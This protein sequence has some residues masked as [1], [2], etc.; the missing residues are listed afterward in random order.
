MR[1]RSASL[2]RFKP[3]AARRL[4][5]RDRTPSA[6]AGPVRWSVLYNC[7]VTVALEAGT[8]LDR[9][10]IRLLDSAENVVLR[11][12]AIAL[13][14][15]YGELDLVF[16]KLPDSF[17]GGTRAV[18]IEVKG[19]GH[20]HRSNLFDIGLDSYIGVIDAIE[21]YE[22][23]GWISPLFN[24]DAFAVELF[25]DGE[26][27]LTGKP[28]RFRTDMMFLSAHGG[29]NGFALP[30][31]SRALDGADH[32]IA[33]RAGRTM[34]RSPTWRSQPE[35]RVDILEQDR[36][37][38]WY[39][40]RGLADRPLSLRL[41]QGEEELASVQSFPRPDVYAHLGRAVAGFSFQNVRIRSGQSIVAGSVD[42]P[43]VVATIHAHPAY[44]RVNALRDVARSLLL[45]RADSTATWVSRHSLQRSTISAARIGATTE[46]E[47][48]FSPV[49]KGPA[50]MEAQA[51]GQ[52][53]EP[54]VGK[55][56]RRHR[57][58]QPGRSTRPAEAQA[59]PA[60]AGG[61]LPPV[62]MIVPV[63]KGLQD[64]EDC[65]AS[66]LLQLDPDRV[67]LVIVDDASPDPK[68]TA[69]LTRFEARR[70]PGVTLLR[71]EINL[72]FIGT[73]NRALAQLRPGED[74]VVL[75]ADT[76]LPPCAIAKLAAIC[77]GRPG[78]ASVT[79]LSNNATILSFPK[80][81]VANPPAGGLSAS[82]ID[83]AFE[84]LGLGPIEIPT[85]IG[86]CMYVNRRAL[87]EVGPLSPRWG[88]GYCEEVEWSLLA[89]DLGWIHLA[90]QN[91][92]VVHEGS[93][94][95]GPQERTD[96]LARNHAALERLFPEYASEIRDFS[97]EDP[98][99]E[100][101]I[102]A[103]VRLLAE[104]FRRWTIH[105]LHGLEGGSRRF[106]DDLRASPREAEHEI[107]VLSPAT[108]EFGAKIL[109]LSLD[110]FEV[111][112]DLGPKGLERFKRAAAEAGLVLR[113]HLSALLGYGQA[114][115][116][117]IVEAS[118][119]VVT[120]HDF[121]WYCPRVH[122]VDDTRFYCGEP[123]PEVCQ[124]CV[125]HRQT[126]DFGR[127]APLIREDL[128][129][130]LATNRSFLA[131][132]DALYAPSRDTAERYRRRL[133]LEAISYQ[134]HLEPVAARVPDGAGRAAL[135]NG[136]LR[137]AVVG[138]IGEHKGYEIVARV[139]ELA[140][141]RQLPLF[142]RVIGYTC[143]DG[144]LSLL[145]NLDITGR[146]EATELKARLDAFDPAFVWLPSVWPETY[147][148]VLSEAWAAGYP[149]V[150]FDFGAPAERIRE[151]GFG[152]LIPVSRDAEEV[153]RGLLR[154]GDTI[155]R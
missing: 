23:I 4:R 49:V 90:A 155:L 99:E 119:Y 133:G 146:F 130:W 149:V 143:D 56:D 80:P 5:S 55:Q 86:F 43:V 14:V 41:M 96:I 28:N 33:I 59:D 52:A 82:E 42:D 75:N 27:C 36:V 48:R 112:F 151:T 144:S 29:W 19:A 79:P 53:S 12:D 115:L 67:R 9:V 62:C 24:I 113:F 134:P 74:T 106:V 126:H 88:R 1:H 7:G 64:L 13:R 54:V 16:L 68:I 50:E 93:V 44:E 65:L 102:P 131:G 105:V 22:V 83:R 25:V 101:R 51:T 34:I 154:A 124:L 120:L 142:I 122:L 136:V 103:L 95:F 128:P 45:S 110:S 98:L 91:T 78:I 35:G 38:G 66:A 94:S 58:M 18:R 17:F 40:D 77:H 148:Y 46:L 147:S 89:R 76:I 92:F 21:V 121:Q 84:A 138:A 81:R 116:A 26:A 47:L 6:K 145:P 104:R 123:P 135:R 153:L 129:A 140:A 72:G 37:E 111:E 39:F 20:C 10:V 100:A 69:F 127:D 30:L 85:A 150:A 61:E 57:D 11:L 73:I 152:A 125:R 60:R 139:A 141:S 137:I 132:A 117:A 118:P 107:G 87:D 31:P 15:N 3:L 71:N 8:D 32:D 108:D 109:R 70:L 63:Y 97:A 114:A 2:N